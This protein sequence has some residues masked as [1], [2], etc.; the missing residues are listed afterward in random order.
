[1]RHPADR[2]HEGHPAQHAKPA[3][4]GNRRL[5]RRNARNPVCQVATDPLGVANQV[6]V[7]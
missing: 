1:M 2:L 5:P 3:Y 7:Q 6:V 4:L